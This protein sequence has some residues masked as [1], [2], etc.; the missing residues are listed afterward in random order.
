MKSPFPG[1]D[2]YLERHWRDVHHRLI[3]FASAA[4]GE[5]LPRDLR[6]RIEE[7]V[8]VGTAPD[9]GRS[10][11]PDACVVERPGVAEAVA[12]PLGAG[13]VAVAEPLV[14]AIDDEPATEGFVHIV[15][16]GSGG[17]VVTVLEILSRSKLPGPGQDQYR[18][19]QRELRAGG[20]SLVEIDLLRAGEHVLVVPRFKVPASHVTTYRVCVSRASRR[21]YVELYRAPLRERLPVI[22]VPLRESDA[23]VP[24]D[25]QA[26]VDRCYREGVYDDIDYR[27]DADPPLDPE[28]AVWADELL[29]SAGRR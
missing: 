26:L 9:A 27:A 19:K 16:A 20:V 8:I 29:R 6:A 1:M 10:I 15:E 25:L 13:S 5:R 11:Y 14:L 2:P 3:S 7:R 23:D 28:D 4:L 17:R 18:Q 21:G 24:L 12:E 22:R